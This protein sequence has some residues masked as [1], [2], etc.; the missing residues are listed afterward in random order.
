ML[1]NTFGFACFVTFWLSV[2]CLYFGLFGIGIVGI[3]LAITFGALAIKAD[4]NHWP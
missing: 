3:I 1:G 2:A 4:N